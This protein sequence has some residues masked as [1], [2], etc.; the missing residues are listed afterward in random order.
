MERYKRI[1]HIKTK[2]NFR[3]S[4]LK[5]NF[6]LFSDEHITITVTYIYFRLI[7]WFVSHCNTPSKREKYVERIKKVI[8]VD[9][10]GHCSDNETLNIA[11]LLRPSK[12]K[13]QFIL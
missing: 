2:V 3:K 7:A 11:I 5:L 1:S 10:Y 13:Q 9:I 8:P 12:F 4:Y 6:P